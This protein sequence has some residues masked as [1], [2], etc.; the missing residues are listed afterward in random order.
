M[1]RSAR[2]DQS[3]EFR[4]GYFQLELPLGV[5]IV[6]HTD[7]GRLSK[8][9]HGAGADVK[10]AQEEQGGAALPLLPLRLVIS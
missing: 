1:G 7:H 2:G 4:H 3:L 6:N 10:L 5:R 8:R 9:C